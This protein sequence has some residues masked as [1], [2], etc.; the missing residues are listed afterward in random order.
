MFG[1]LDL[2]ITVRG[3]MRVFLIAVVIRT[4][5]SSATA[6]PVNRDPAAGLQ[7]RLVPFCFS[8]PDPLVLVVLT[9]LHAT[10]P[11]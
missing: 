2:G 8:R 3:I 10:D 11:S 6:P 4:R 1:F 9:Q 7:I 5:P